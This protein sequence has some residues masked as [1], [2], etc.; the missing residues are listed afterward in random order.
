MRGM[1]PGICGSSVR[2]REVGKSARGPFPYT[3][4]GRLT[5]EGNVNAARGER[6]TLGG[7]A[8]TVLEDPGIEVVLRLLRQAEVGVRNALE[9]VVV[10]LRRPEDARGRV[11]HVPTRTG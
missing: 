9:D 5:D 11:R 6:A 8:Q 4:G 1:R 10:V 3:R 2:V 7:P